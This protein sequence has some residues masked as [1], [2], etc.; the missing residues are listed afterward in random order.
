VTIREEALVT[1]SGKPLHLEME[2][3]RSEYE[4]LIRG[5]VDSTLDSVS[6]ALQD[7]GK[8]P[9]DMDAVLL[10]GGSTRTPWPSIY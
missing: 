10:V 4:S 3:S 6:E 7:A 1:R 8:K 9:G 2:I 5:L